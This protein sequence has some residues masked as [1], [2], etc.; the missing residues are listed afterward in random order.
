[1]LGDTI[2]GFLFVVINTS[3][4]PGPSTADPNPLGIPFGFEGQIIFVRSN[5]ESRFDVQEGGIVFTGNGVPYEP[6]SH[7]ELEYRFLANNTD[8]AGPFHVQFAYKVFLEPP[9][10]SITND[11]TVENDPPHD[12][13]YKS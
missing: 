9:F 10:L 4:G 11:P 3:Q 13:P 7:S 8:D 5:P 1:M 12:P 6:F 2:P